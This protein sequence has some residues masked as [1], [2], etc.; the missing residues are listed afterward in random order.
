MSSL[1]YDVA[2]LI[3]TFGYSTK[4]VSATVRSFSVFSLR[5]AAKLSG[6]SSSFIS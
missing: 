6:W 3:I 1:D 2:G 4:N 5:N